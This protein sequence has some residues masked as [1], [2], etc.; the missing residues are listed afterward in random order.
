MNFASTAVLLIMV[1]MSVIPEIM[2][3]LFLTPASDDTA[4]EVP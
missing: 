4:V 2:G 3:K 1:R